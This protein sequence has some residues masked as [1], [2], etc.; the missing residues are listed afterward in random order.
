MKKRSSNFRTRNLA[1]CF[2]PPEA[3]LTVDQKGTSVLAG[4]RV[5]IRLSEFVPQTLPHSRKLRVVV[6]SY[7]IL[8]PS[9]V[10]FRA[11]KRVG[12]CCNLRLSRTSG[13]SQRLERWSSSEAPCN[14]RET[15][16]GSSFHPSSPRGWRCSAV[17]MSYPRR[18]CSR[19]ACP[20]KTSEHS[21]A[22]ARIL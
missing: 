1:V 20:G 12:T 17:G 9:F 10:A 15:S 18:T 11:S 13:A 21:Q 3:S 6:F 2:T 16:F 5:R 22:C 19:S 7:L 4:S 8:N 14:R